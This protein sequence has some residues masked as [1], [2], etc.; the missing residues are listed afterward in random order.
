M[1]G[2]TELLI[3][4][5]ATITVNLTPGPDM[6]YVIARSVSQ[7]KKAGIVSSLG[8]STGCLAHTLA[9]ALGLSA[10]LAQSSVAFDVIKYVGAG[11]LIYLGIKGLLEKDGTNSLTEEHSSLG[12]IFRQGVI[13]NVFNPKVALFFLAFL[14]QFVH[15]SNGPVALQLVFLGLL[16]VFSG[17]IWNC[18]VAL[19]AGQMGQGLKKRLG[20]WKAQKWFSSFVFIV[21][22]ARLVFIKRG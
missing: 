22:G 2:S 19:M 4:L 15:R 21:L 12:K 10:L 6:L 20:L 3:F 18:L 7:G 16:F 17:T 14:P 8:I 13:T 1:P 11:Y 5:A 9:T